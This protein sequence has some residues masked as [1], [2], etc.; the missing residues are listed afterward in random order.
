MSD[1]VCLIYRLPANGAMYAIVRRCTGSRPHRSSAHAARVPPVPWFGFRDGQ[2][3]R[4]V[5]RYRTGTERGRAALSRQLPFV[6]NLAVVVRRRAACSTKTR[7]H[8]F[9]KNRGTRNSLTG[10]D[11]QNQTVRNCTKGTSAPISRA[12]LLW[13]K[14]AATQIGSPAAPSAAASILREGRIDLPRSHARRSEWRG[15][16]RGPRRLEQLPR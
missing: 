15:T 11:F 4:F 6:Q 2:T 12:R 10:Q 5:G 8:R 1:D 13:T 3:K 9:C 14:R 7:L 16:R